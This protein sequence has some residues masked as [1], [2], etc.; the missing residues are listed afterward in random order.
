[1]K[2]VIVLVLALLVAAGAFTGCSKQES[3]EETSSVIP[4]VLNT[5]EYT[6]YQNIFYNDKAGEYNGQEVTKEGTFATLHDAYSDVTRYYVWGYNDNTKCCDWQWE[7]KIDDVNNLPANGCLVTVKGTYETNDA[8]LDGLWIVNPEISVKTKYKGNSY[9]IDMLSMSNTLERVQI[10]NVI[11]FPDKFSGKS[12]GFYGRVKSDNE[13]EDTYYDNS[14]SVTVN[15][16][17]EV[18]AFGT[19]MIATG[20]VGDG[21]ID[22]VKLSDNTQY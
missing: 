10:T 4:T 2:K 6:L 3:K 22:D 12:I 7:L 8:A 14:W 13:I 9:D 5:V 19:K 17:F 1:M 21:V 18:P 20:T 16:D 11:N 15:G